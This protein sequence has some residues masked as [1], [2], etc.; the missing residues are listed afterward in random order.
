MKILVAG[1]GNLL[2]CDDGLGPHVI[3]ELA[4][5][6]LPS[7]VDVMDLGTS[8]MDVL[9]YSAGHDKA[10]FIDAV[11]LGK[12][13][14]TVYRITPREVEI[15]DEDFRGAIY[16]SMHEINLERVI[17]LG[18]R[19]GSVPKEIVIIGC[20][21]EDTTSMKIELTEKVAAAVPKIIELL[22]E[23]LKSSS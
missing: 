6:S 7:D 22:I 3:K 12:A 4:K 19:L 20:E 17:A 15:T 8:A 18:R 5:I 16:M 23:E 1:V 2:R 21:P 10:I 13:V 11:K 9:H 14:G